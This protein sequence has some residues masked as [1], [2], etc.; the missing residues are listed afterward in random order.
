MDKLKLIIVNKYSDY[1]IFDNKIG[2]V[3]NG[4][5]DI[6]KDI[7]N[8]VKKFVEKYQL[9]FDFNILIQAEDNITNEL[10]T[11]CDKVLEEIFYI[12]SRNRE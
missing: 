7:F 2:N 3:Q 4:G 8:F 9:N 1:L 12:F 11:K 5:F 10:K 6:F